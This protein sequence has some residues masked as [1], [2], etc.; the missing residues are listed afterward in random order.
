MA[1]HNRIYATPSQTKKIFGNIKKVGKDF[2]GRFTSLFQTMMVQAQKEMG[3]ESIAN[4]AVNEE[5]DDRLV[6]A[7][8]TASSLEAEQDSGNIA[9]TQYKNR[10]FDLEDTKN[11]QT[12]EI[13]SLKRRVKN[14][15]KK[16]RSRTHKLKSL[17][18]VELS[19][20]LESS[21]DEGL[22]EED[23]SKQG[24]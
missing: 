13:Y 11:S 18:K 3:E 17:S 1:N 20:R 9:M 2:F 14:L 10:V 16:Q 5:M 24:G 4:E 12:Q 8:T 22:G 15:K 7:A 23:A 21:D 19:A 6:R